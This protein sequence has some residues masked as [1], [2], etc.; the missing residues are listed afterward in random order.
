MLGSFS[1]AEAYTVQCWGWGAVQLFAEYRVPWAT[2]SLGVPLW[3]LMDVLLVCTGST[4][5]GEAIMRFP[6]PSSELLFE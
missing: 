3:H 6:G 5:G 4:P 2:R 1:I